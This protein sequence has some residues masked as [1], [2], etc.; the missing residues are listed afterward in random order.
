MDTKQRT[1]VAP[2]GVDG[3][4]VLQRPSPAYAIFGK[5]VF[6]HGLSYSDAACTPRWEAGLL[7]TEVL[8]HSSCVYTRRSLHQTS[9]CNWAPALQTKRTDAR[10]RQGELPRAAAGNRT[11]GCAAGTLHWYVITCFLQ[12]EYRT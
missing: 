12:Q 4:C 5:V 7:R 3:P 10:R 6:S 8:V 9:A 1:K 2:S 11:F